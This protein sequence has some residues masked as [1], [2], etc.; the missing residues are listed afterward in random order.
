VRDGA[1]FGNIVK[2]DGRLYWR[3]WEKYDMSEV[4]MDRQCK[5]YEFSNIDKD[6]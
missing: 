1:E 4:G 3:K 2:S 5:L 6:R